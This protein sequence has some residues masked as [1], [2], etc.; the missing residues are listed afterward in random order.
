MV[1]P[2]ISGMGELSPHPYIGM[3]R[4]FI[5]I[6]NIWWC[7]TRGLRTLDVAGLGIEHIER[8]KINGEDI[9]IRIVG[10]R[11][12]RKGFDYCHIGFY[13]IPPEGD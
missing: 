6:D 3:W 5:T 13:Y 4:P 7:R 11:I 9:H 10:K 1:T 8:E 2:N 12:K